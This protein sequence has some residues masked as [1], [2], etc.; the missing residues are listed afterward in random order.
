MK[1]GIL[2]VIVGAVLFAVPGCKTFS[3]PAK[4]ALKSAPVL[5][6]GQSSLTD[7]ERYYL[8]TWQ[9]A[10]V[11][12]DEVSDYDTALD[13]YTKLADYFPETSEGKNAVKRLEQLKKRCAK[14]KI[15]VK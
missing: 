13:Y 10:A 1:Q 6:Q 7:E 5:A 4:P 11:L 8:Q 12:A 14:E 15:P 2:L 9:H 3:E